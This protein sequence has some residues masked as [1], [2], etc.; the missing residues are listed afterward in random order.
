MKLIGSYKNGNYEVHIFDDG[1]KIRVNHDECFTAEY[2][3][4]IDIKICNRC[5]MGCPMCH[6]QS[7]KDG[8]LA[9][10]N[11]L[12]LNSI[13]PYTELAIGGGNPLEHPDLENFLKKMQQQK[14]ICNMTVNIWHFAENRVKLLEY[15]KQGLIHGLG[16]SVN[17]PLSPYIIKRIQSFPN[18][19]VHVITG[20]VPDQA[21][22][23]L[24]DKNIRLLVL[25][26]KDFGRGKDYYSNHQDINDRIIAFANKLPEYANH[27][28]VISFDNL[29]IKQLSIKERM[30]KQKWNTCY[31]GNDG[32]FTMYIDL[33]KEEYAI[34]SVSKR[35][36]LFSND[37]DKVFA[38]VKQERLDG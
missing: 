30:P 35:H 6:E 18:A 38:A 36:P 16:I 20:I 5:D 7:T 1:T 9:N 10:L 17:E 21:I 13:H 29:A 37:I 2:P 32:E 33:V 34:S 26:Y 11:H 23:E 25:G 14:V 12:I 24:Y 8:A 15:S 19:V 3:E 22:Q 4:S 31:M 27:F 28:P